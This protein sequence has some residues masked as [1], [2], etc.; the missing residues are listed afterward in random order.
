MNVIN[1]LLFAGYRREEPILW[2]KKRE[3]LARFPAEFVAPSSVREMTLLPSFP[4]ACLPPPR[5]KALPFSTVT[6][7]L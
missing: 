4:R 2:N 7:L 6:I 5:V 3:E 1:R